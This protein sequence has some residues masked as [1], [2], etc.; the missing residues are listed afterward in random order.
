[1]ITQYNLFLEWKDGSICKNQ[2]NIPHLQNKVEKNHMIT[3]NS[4]EKAFDKFQYPFTIKILNKLDIE[5]NY[6][7]ITRSHV[8]N[9]EQTSHSIV[10]D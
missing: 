4:E 3:S 6:P 7:N 1:M 2:S 9:P 8:K 10:K 5:G